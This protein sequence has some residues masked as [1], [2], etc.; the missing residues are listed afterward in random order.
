MC[1][2]LAHFIYFLLDKSINQIQNKRIF[3]CV[4]SLSNNVFTEHN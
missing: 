2:T 1:Y 3:D 4:M